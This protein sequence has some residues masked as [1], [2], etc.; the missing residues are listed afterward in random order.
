MSPS[1]APAAAAGW[2]H[3][4]HAADVGVRGFGKSAAE[5][6]EQAARALTAVVTNAEVIPQV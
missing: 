3:F 2:E 4:P 6:F 1:A 5:A